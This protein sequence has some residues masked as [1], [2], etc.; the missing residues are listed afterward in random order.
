MSKTGWKIIDVVMLAVMLFIFTSVAQTH[1][2]DIVAVCLQGVLA[3]LIFVNVGRLLAQCYPKQHAK[4]VRTY[5]ELCFAIYGYLLKSYIEKGYLDPN[6]GGNT[7]D[8]MAFLFDE[9]LHRVED[10]LRRM[11]SAKLLDMK[12][13]RGRGV[14]L[15]AAYCIPQHVKPWVNKK[16][17]LPNLE[18]VT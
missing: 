10:A 5:D 9:P 2:S 3:F 16:H 7:A 12:I 14:P 18:H 8:F 11:Q 15:W 4:T 17:N 1:H 13:V 6:Q